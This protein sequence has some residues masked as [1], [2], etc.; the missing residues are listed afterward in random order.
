M[1]AKCLARLDRLVE[2]RDIYTQLTKDR[3]GAADVDA[4][5]GLGEVAFMLKDAQRVK[6]CAA[7]LIAI[8]PQSPEG[9]ILRGLQNRRTGDLAA[10]KMNFEQALHLRRDSNTLVL[11][12]MV[13]QD[14]NLNSAARNSFQQALKDQPDNQEAQRLLSSVPTQ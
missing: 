3:D 5:R 13:Q 7:R 14:M 8:A 4:W 6:L 9:W 2:C 10:A 1:R 11:L 12:G